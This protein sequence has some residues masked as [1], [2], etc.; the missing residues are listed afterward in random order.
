MKN[1]KGKQGR[2]SLAVKEALN[3]AKVGGKE[4]PVTFGH[5]KDLAG[6]SVE[7]EKHGWVESETVGKIPN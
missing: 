4:I 1:S 6:K 2:F 7:N 3:V 5:S